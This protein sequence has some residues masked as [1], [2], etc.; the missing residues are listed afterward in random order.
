[1]SGAWRH[2]QGDRERGSSD[3]DIGEDLEREERAG[4]GAR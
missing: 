1:M 3:M 4:V 2:A